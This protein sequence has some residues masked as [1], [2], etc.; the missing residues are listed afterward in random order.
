MPIHSRNFRSSEFLSVKLLSFQ[1]IKDI[2]SN[3]PTQTRRTTRRVTRMY[4]R[5]SLIN[6]KRK[7]EDEI[8]DEVS[9]NV[10]APLSDVTLPFFLFLSFVS[11]QRREGG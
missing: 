6:R 7:Y 4:Q 5:N 3:E 9:L 11:F 8:D 10:D 1:L 2:I